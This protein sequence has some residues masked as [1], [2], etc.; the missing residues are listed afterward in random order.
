[1]SN[2]SNA[3][4][5]PPNQQPLDSYSVG[6]TPNF[7]S[8]QQT[9]G[10]QQEGQPVAA[11]MG[12]M[13]VYPIDTPKYVMAFSIQQYNRS[14]LNRVGTFVA[15]GYPGI[16]LP[17]P[18]QLSNLNESK[19]SEQDTGLMSLAAASIS[20]LASLGPRGAQGAGTLNAFVNQVGGAA[21]KVVGEVGQAWL[22]ATPN[23]FQVML[24]RGPSYKQ[25]SFTWQLSPQ[26]FKEA[27]IIRMMCLT[28]QNAMAP[29]IVT[30]GGSNVGQALWGFPQVFRIRLYPNSK[31]MY[32]FKPCVLTHFTVNYTPAGRPSFARNVNGQI[33]ENPP[34]G[35]TIQARFMEMEYWIAGNYTNYND[36]EDTDV[37]IITQPIG[38]YAPKAAPIIPSPNGGFTRTQ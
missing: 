33:G 35:I 6:T 9:Q 31:W 21:G 10:V 19:W 14:S 2:L 38:D 20:G 15:S 36:P 1:M 28:F 26:N 23:Q 32:K 30:V 5:Q 16:V 29:T 22:G 27:D 8:F 12:N 37:N 4:Y 3:P 34:E 13:L 18:E 7:P 24:Y 17:L 11:Q 25:H